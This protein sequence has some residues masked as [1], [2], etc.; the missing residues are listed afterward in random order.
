[1]NALK[2]GCGDWCY[3]YFNGCCTNPAQCDGSRTFSRTTADTNPDVP[4]FD[5]CEIHKN[6]TVEVWR[7]SVTGQ[8]SVGWYENE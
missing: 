2:T 1:M 5:E 6:C 4:I 3:Y 8:I 7:N